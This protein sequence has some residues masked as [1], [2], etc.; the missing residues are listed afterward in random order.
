MHL[1]SG[2]ITPFLPMGYTVAFQ[3]DRSPHEGGVLMMCKSH[4]LDVIDCTDCYVEGACEIV[5]VKF[6]GTTILCV[7]RQPGNTNL[8]L[9]ESLNRF[10]TT[11]NLPMPILMFTIKNDLL[12]LI[13]PLLADLFG[14]FVS[15]M[16][17]YNLLIL[18]HVAPQFWI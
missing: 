3:K 16:A 4:L 6:Q 14:S 17:R 15:L 12:D 11:H 9:T 8:T 7:Y 13:L 2:P 10:I 1:D 5:A 18:P